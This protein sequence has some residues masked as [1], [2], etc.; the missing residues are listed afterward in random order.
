MLKR[1]IL[2]I[3]ALLLVCAGLWLVL[4]LNGASTFGELLDK[5]LNYDGK[6]PSNSRV[7]VNVYELTN[8][9]AD[10][11][12]NVFDSELENAL[13]R[14]F[15]EY[16]RVLGTLADNADAFGAL[17][18]AYSP[19]RAVDALV[20]ERLVKTRR[21]CSAPLTFSVCD[22]GLRLISAAYADV[23][24]VEIKVNECFA[25]VFDG[26]GEKMSSYAG[27]EHFFVFEK[28]GGN[29]LVRR[30]ES[31]SAFALYITGELDKIIAENGYA[32]GQ[33]TSGAI[34]AYVS[35]LGGVLERETYYYPAEKGAKSADFPYDRAKAT[36]YAAAQTEREKIRRNAVFPSYARNGTNFV[37]QC[38]NAGGAPENSAWNGTTASWINA[39]AFY[40][41]V[42]SEKSIIAAG[43]CGRREGEAGDVIQF[44]D[45][46]GGA[47]QSALITAKYADEYLITAN[48]EDFS[49]F[50]AAATGFDIIRVIKIYGFN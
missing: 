36:E 29:W 14:W 9:N 8:D 43:V 41:Y 24:L 40:E 48:S 20:L 5:L 4:F 27:T 13:K 42:S 31:D 30:H 26:F 1:L 6:K 15:V 50:P 33:L 7:A 37:S 12:K 11:F 49:M 18:D 28:I 45:G 19:S 25:T 16:N 21:Q 2:A 34:E 46:G 22:V 32:R 17:Y 3:A 39:D 10:N 44:L 23:E 35:T 47:A 38:L